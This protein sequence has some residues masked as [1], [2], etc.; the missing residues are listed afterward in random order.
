MKITI[1]ELKGFVFCVLNVLAINIGVAQNTPLNNLAVQDSLKT[2]GNNEL[3]KTPFGVFNIGQT[4]GAVFRISGDELRKSGGDNLINSLRG[5][6]PGLRIVRT[7]NTPGNGGYSYT[8]NGGTPNV[9]IDGQP[10]GLQVDLRDVDE[11]IVLSDATFNALL[12]N[13]GDNGLIYVVTKGNKLSKPAIEVN[14]QVG[15]STPTHLP[16]LLSASEYAT[17]INEASN[18][19]GL[20]NVYSPEAIEAYKN[21]SDPINFPN[22]DT[23]ETY[24]SNLAASNYMSLN[25]YGASEKVSY[26]AFL[27][28][29]DWEG[30]EK[31]GSKIDGRN[32]TFRTKIDTKINDLVKAHAS[33]YGRFGENERPVIGPD[34]TFRWITNTPAN[35]FPLMVGDS[36]YV[37]NNQFQTNLLSELENGGTRTDYTSNMI[38]DIG[39]DFDLDQFVPGLAY[40]TYIMMKTYN[41]HSLLTNN[42]PALYTLENLEDTNG[43]DSLALKVYKNEVLD[44]SIGRTGGA[45][46]RNFAYG[47]N[48]SYVKETAKG[49][50]NLNLSHLLFYQPNIT[51]SQTD[52]RNFTVN[53]NGSYA[54][55]NKYILFAN[56]NS[57]SSSRFLDNHK[58]KMYPTVG[59]AWVASN[60]NF[61]K[62][63]KVIDYLKFR[64]SYGIVGTEYGFTTLLY[65]DTWS[66]GRN[67][68]TTYLGTNGN[69][70]QD[71]LGY[72]LNTTGNDEIDWVEY[73]QLFAGVELQMF[74]KLKL[75]FNYFNILIN[76]QVIRA[77]QLYASA[78][79]NDVYLPQLNF[80]ESRNKGFNTNITFSDSKDSFKYHISANAGYNKVIGE[81]IAEVQ[82]PDEYRLQQG[83]AQDNIVGYVSDGLYT[84]ENIGSALPQFGD[85]QVGDVKYVDLNGDNVIDSRDTKTIGNSNPRVNYGINFGFEYKGINL[86]VVGMGVTGYDINLN[87]YAYYQHGGL[88]NYYGSVN[89]DLPNG[90]ANPRLSTLTSINNNKNS[91]YWLLNG[92]YFKIANVELGYSLPESIIS[93]SSFADVK[94]FLRGSNLAVFSKMKDLDPENINAG[95]SQ[96]PMMRTFTLGASINF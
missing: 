27:G 48:L 88:G 64:T 43:L 16:K 10:R 32:I 82:Y 89:S 94:L 24:L 57:S 56:A 83:Q 23:Q 71:E 65:L 41:A 4:T 5:R 92:G 9:L 12:G 58:T 86:D 33:V 49:I 74:K 13:L 60:E 14:Y 1:K 26:S 73:N 20:G 8:L 70:S 75:D 2:K 67:N 77:S 96:Y 30:L 28:Y 34:D 6:V 68:G 80:K 22:V 53:L 47:G 95:F 91:D 84:A 46:Q 40:D 31:V 85:L 59:A 52:Q 45:I 3:L 51:A 17:I 35:A 38:F 42:Q 15:Y 78:L 37:V 90:N 72:R 29:S 81:K 11:V 39:F 63:S 61:L 76:N 19:D 87:S 93:D 55:E 66:G 7:S 21:G 36:A 50:L 54:L 79:G 25:L 44:L 69:L 18:N 62:D